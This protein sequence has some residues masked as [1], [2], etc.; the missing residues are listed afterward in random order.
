MI[1]VITL[2]PSFLKLLVRKFGTVLRND[3]QAFAPLRLRGVRR[4]EADARR[5][6]EDA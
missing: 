4:T 3:H 2:P 1:A 5:D 6:Q